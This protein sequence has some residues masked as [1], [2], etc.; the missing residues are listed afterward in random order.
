ML[1][2]T[3]P[4]NV[5]VGINQWLNYAENVGN[6]KGNIC[7]TDLSLSVHT[8]PDCV[9]W[10][11]NSCASRRLRADTLA[12]LAPVNRHWVSS[13]R[14]APQLG[15]SHESA[16]GGAERRKQIHNQ[17]RLEVL[18]SCCD[19]CPGPVW[20]RRGRTSAAHWQGK[21]KFYGPGGSRWRGAERG[22][23]G[24]HSRGV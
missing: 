6:I 22:D 23:G 18:T 10:I 11:L 7:W 4:M 3:P 16:E 14:P 24:F 9:Q 8:V 13:R 5:F 1:I 17:P 20:E 21:G 19:F 12:K 15:D 2:S